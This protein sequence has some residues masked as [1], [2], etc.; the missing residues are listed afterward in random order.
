MS[1][2]WVTDDLRSHHVWPLEIRWIGEFCLSLNSVSINQSSFINPQVFR[3]HGE[4]KRNAGIFFVQNTFSF[5]CSLIHE[6]SQSMDYDNPQFIYQLYHLSIS[7]SKIPPV[8]NCWTPQLK[9]MIV[10]HHQPAT[11]LWAPNCSRSLAPGHRAAAKLWHLVH[12]ASGVDHVITIYL[13]TY[14]SIC[15]LSR[16]MDMK[17]WM[18]IKD[19]LCILKLYSGWKYDPI[20]W[21]TMKCG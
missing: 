19:I 12:G 3:F 14:L 21:N 7:G 4:G 16:Y 9:M 5:H 13:P 20:R 18:M 11:G 10:R 15:L 8:Q 1:P 6:D 2:P 17:S